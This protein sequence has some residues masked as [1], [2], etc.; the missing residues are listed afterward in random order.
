[1]RLTFSIY[2]ATA[3][4]PKRLDA[5]ICAAFSESRAVVKRWFDAGMVT[6]HARSLKP[7]ESVKDKMEIILDGYESKSDRRL[8]PNPSLS[9]ELLYEDDQLLVMNKPR[10]I[11]VNALK[12]TETQT[13]ANF[14]ITHA[15]DIATWDTRVLE[16]GIVHRLDQWTSG[17]L[18]GVKTP[19]A[20]SNLQAQFKNRTLRKIY[21]AVVSGSLTWEEEWTD[22]LTH[23]PKNNRKMCIVAPHVL[24][25][26]ARIAT[27]S[28]RPLHTFTRADETF[29]LVEIQLKTGRMHQIRLQFSHRGYPVFGDTLYKAKPQKNFQGYWLHAHHIEFSHPTTGNRLFCT[30]PIPD[31]LKQCIP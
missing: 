17:C 14:L 28:F 24:N 8:V 12:Y 1:M 2:P 20:L 7:S 9:V 10:G 23:D 25:P 27:L 4:S 30:A 31:E 5:Y 15:P 29:T 26:K 13:I 19:H 18:V 22:R 16:P 11:S 6:T 3:I 21:L